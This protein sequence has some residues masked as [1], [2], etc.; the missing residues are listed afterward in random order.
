MECYYNA[1]KE[2]ASLSE[3]DGLEQEMLPLLMLHGFERWDYSRMD[4][5]ITPH[6]LQ[7]SINQSVHLDDAVLTQ[8]DMVWGH[9][10]IIH[11]SRISLAGPEE[12][13]VEIVTDLHEHIYFPRG[14]KACNEEELPVIGDV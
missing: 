9:D 4:E 1:W 6:G 14:Y 5:L 12:R 7:R 2:Y 8:Q 11:T 13:V 10:N 3:F